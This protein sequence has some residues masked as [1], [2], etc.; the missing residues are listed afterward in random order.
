MLQIG[1]HV[2]VGLSERTNAAA[3]EQL[4]RIVAAAYAP[5]SG[6]GGGDSDAAT[7]PPP[8]PRVEAV[9][10][11]RGLHLKSACSA[12]DAATL[13]LSDDAAGA[14]VAAELRARLPA[15]AA[16]L[17]FETV[18]G[19]A[20]AANVL[21]VNASVVMQ[22]AAAPAAEAR[23]RGLCGARGLALRVV[24][25]MTEFI[26]ADGAMTCCSVLLP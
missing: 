4:R 2:L 25:R 3:V 15:L 6:S 13:L 9:A 14:A 8:P 18:P 1:G 21:R 7:P 17:A 24:P 11:A 26:K 19:D 10:V 20:L 12:L 5:A 22:R 23:L 16:R